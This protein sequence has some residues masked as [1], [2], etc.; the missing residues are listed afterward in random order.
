MKPDVRKEMCS[1]YIFMCKVNSLV[2][3]SNITYN[4]VLLRC[5]HTY[6]LRSLLNLNSVEECYLNLNVDCVR[7]ASIFCVVEDHLIRRAKQARLQVCIVGS[8]K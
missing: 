7:P 2:L 6:D 3:K 8:F 4:E 1:L 5:D